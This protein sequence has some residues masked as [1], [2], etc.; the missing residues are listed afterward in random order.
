MKVNPPACVPKILCFIIPCVLLYSHLY[1]QIPDDMH[2]PRCR[3]YQRIGMTQVEIS[4]SRPSLKGRSLYG[5]IIEEGKEWRTGANAATTI[6]FDDPVL[7]KGKPLK[8]GIYALYTIPNRDSWEIIFNKNIYKDP[9]EG[10][11]K[12]LDALH[13]N[14]PVLSMDQPVET[15]TISVSDISKDHVSA[16][17]DLMWENTLVKMP[18]EVPKKWG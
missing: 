2:S 5:G 9:Y 3:M 10:R 13:L 1:S 11:T 18:L 15:F 12:G 17:I 7:I 14:I 4:Y 6:R 16:S 8:A